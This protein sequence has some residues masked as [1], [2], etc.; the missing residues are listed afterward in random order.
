MPRQRQL[1]QGPDG[2]P[3]RL[4]RNQIYTYR[5]DQK[6]KRGAY[7]RTA[8]PCPFDSTGNGAVN[9]NEHCKND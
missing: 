9:E 6:A 3:I 5:A 4:E 8:D 2:F 1:R 7:D